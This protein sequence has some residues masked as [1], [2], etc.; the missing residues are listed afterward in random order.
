MNMHS[1]TESVLVDYDDAPDRR[2][3]NPLHRLLR[4]AGALSTLLMAAP[5]AVFVAFDMVF[6]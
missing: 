1:A 2:A 6:R 5:F 4:I 3:K